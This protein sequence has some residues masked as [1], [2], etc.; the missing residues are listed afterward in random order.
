VRWPHAGGGVRLQ[1]VSCGTCATWTCNQQVNSRERNRRAARAADRLVLEGNE[2]DQNGQRRPVIIG[3]G[4]IET[5][6]VGL[7]IVLEIER[8]DLQ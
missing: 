7:S 1:A 3:Y 2:P 6:G 8:P 5:D 4:S